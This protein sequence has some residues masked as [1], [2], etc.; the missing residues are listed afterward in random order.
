MFAESRSSSIINLLNTPVNDDAEYRLL[1]LTYL[2]ADKQCP[3]FATTYE[4]I[5]QKIVVNFRTHEVLLH[6]EAI[7]NIIDFLGVLAV[8]RMC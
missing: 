4:N 7:L 5:E 3:D 1:E 8:D 2:M 6:Q